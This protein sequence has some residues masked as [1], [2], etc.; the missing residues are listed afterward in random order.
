MFQFNCLVGFG[1]LEFMI[2]GIKIKVQK[3]VVGGFVI[4]VFFGDES[5]FVKSFFFNKF[6]FVQFYKYLG[7]QCDDFCLQYKVNKVCVYIVVVV[8]DNNKL[9]EY[10]NSFLKVS[11]K[12]RLDVLCIG[13][14]EVGKKK[15]YK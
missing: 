5:C 12:G 6:Y 15:S 8:Y 4:R 3:L 13:K 7:Y 14:L 9:E 2:N 1:F 10:I 11:L